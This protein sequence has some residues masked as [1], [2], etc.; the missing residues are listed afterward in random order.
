MKYYD[1]YKLLNDNRLIT[2]IWKCELDLIN[3]IIDIED[4]DIYLE[5]FSIYFS[6]I[7]SG[8]TCMSL[9]EKILSNK[10]NNI[11]DGAHKQ[12]TNI[13]NPNL[14]YEN[15]YNL[16]KEES[17]KIIN[18]N[19]L[20]KLINVDI[21]S[22]SNS[23]NKIFEID[24]NYLYLRKYYN[25]R[26]GIKDSINRLFVPF[27]NNFKSIDFNKYIPE[28]FQLSEGQ[29]EVVKKGL[30][31]NLVV[32]GG[33]GTGKTTSI[34]YLLLNILANDNDY[35]IYLAAAAGKA[36]GRMKDSLKGGL[37]NII[38]NQEIMNINGIK[39]A[40][41]KISGSI[42]DD[43]K[44]IEEFTIHRLLK[45]DNNTKK[46]TYNKNNQFPV[47]SIFIIDEASMIDIC[48]FNNLL[49]SIPTGA[50]LF[51]LGDKDQLPSVEVGAVFS[52]LL[53]VLNNDN[54][55]VIKKNQRFK[56]GTEI[57]EFA[58]LV[59]TDNAN[60]ELE[61]KTFNKYDIFKV[62]DITIGNYPIYFYENENNNKEQEKS[63][64]YIL[65]K[66][67]NYFFK[68]NDIVKACSNLDK[69]NID[70][71]ELSNIFKYTT[72]SK[73]I[74]AENDGVRGVNTIN[75][76]I[77]KLIYKNGIT[78]DIKKKSLN[79]NYAGQIMMVNT[80]NKSLDLYN[81]DM[82]L[83]ITFKND[84]T[85]YLMVNKKTKLNLDNNRETDKIFKIDDFI[86][87]PFRLLSLNEI[88]L[89]YAITV[90]KSQ[91]S[92]YKQIF[93]ILP[94]TN[95]H[96][97]LNRQIL[98]TAITRTKGNTYILSNKELLESAHNNLIIRDT[99]IN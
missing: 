28:K 32:T 26:I 52:E 38:N 92:D 11:L 20:N 76:I 68:N 86:F 64:N 96:P 84:D 24:N 55:V 65:N 59:N 1:F 66:W 41:D 27:N 79:N 42:K 69:D 78:E 54:K 10:W 58:K 44:K 62:E 99:K 34:L 47:K 61:K 9:D 53:K 3:E 35:N 19:Y 74:C 7:C 4:K 8:N 15:N 80:N 71:K 67:I 63:I 16:L 57:C 14:E 87:Y 51:I 37:D 97:L 89:A 46:F 17:N 45:I 93:V 88:D 30:N 13:D 18:N 83:L 6:L 94:T 72:D 85:L 95:G 77:K 60:L 40:V 49:N 98:Y 23:N 43:D 31:N 50:R 5:L 81:G 39:E 82:G 56:D 70:S 73:I 75:K 36:A 48:L 29:E 91:G 21:V 2:P 22:N 33:P 90:H 12:L 25:A